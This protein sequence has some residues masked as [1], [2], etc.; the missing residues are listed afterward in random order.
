ME[1]KLV[2]T[3][4]GILAFVGILVRIIWTDLKSKIDKNSED[5]SKCAT[6]AEL[7]EQK[8]DYKADMDII[9][10]KLD[11]ILEKLIAG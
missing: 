9:H 2:L 3:S 11:M 4:S 5:I 1:I 10:K 8:A 6:K 7:L